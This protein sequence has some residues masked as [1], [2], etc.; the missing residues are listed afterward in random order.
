MQNDDP[1]VQ[2]CKVV[3]EFESAIGRQQNV[4]PAIA[5][6]ND[7]VIAEFVP[8]EIDRRRY[9]MILKQI[10]DSRINARVYEDQRTRL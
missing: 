4:K 1:E 5:T 7:L 10:R 8:T 2:F 9:L 3:L 6:R